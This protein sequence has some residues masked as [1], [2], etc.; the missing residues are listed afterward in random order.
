MVRSRIARAHYEG[1]IAVANRTHADNSISGVAWGKDRYNDNPSA[2]A[3]AISLSRI[4]TLPAGASS[5]GIRTASAFLTSRSR[6]IA[7]TGPC[8]VADIDSDRYPSAIS[9]SAPI[10]LDAIS[11]HRQADLFAALAFCTI[12]RS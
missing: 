5:S 6:I 11:P 2:S 8:P 12:W 10:G 1:W 4:D 7:L 9:A 3:N